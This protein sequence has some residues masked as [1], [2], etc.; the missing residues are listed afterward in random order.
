VTRRDGV[1]TSD[2]GEAAPGRGKGGED[3][4]WDDT[5]LTGQKNK[6]NPCR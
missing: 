2:G 5:N 4:S 3:T 1:A 6:E